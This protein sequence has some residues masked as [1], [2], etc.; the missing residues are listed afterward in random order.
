[1]LR[2]LLVVLIAATPLAAC[3]SESSQGAAGAAA[4]SV[5]PSAAMAATASSLSSADAARIREAL[6][7]LV[8]NVS[9]EEINETRIPD[10]YEVFVGGQV[11]YISRDGNTLVQGAMY[12]IPS[13]TDLSE[14]SKARRRVPLL[15]EVG[16][17]GRIIFGDADA[18]HR[19]TVFTDIDCGYCRRMHEE[20]AQYNALG[21]AVEYL[22]F[23]RGGPNTEAWDKS[24]SVWCADDQL[25]AMTRAKAG[26]QV[27]QRSCDNPVADDY[28]LGRKVG[29]EG[30][31]AVY[32]ADGIQVGGYL[33]PQQM[34]QRLEMLKANS[35]S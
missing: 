33:P 13:R 12:D 32:N 4:P 22:F 1:M 7:E 29:V 2:S 35:G 10:L 15:E 8:P 25:D 21:I 27:P 3:A 16:P 31:P 30:T 6:G 11:L 9:I 19:V 34:L 5:A 20:I 18:A 17:E 24:V 26:Q 28:E 23:P 14:R